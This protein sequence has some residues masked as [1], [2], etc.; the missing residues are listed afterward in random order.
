MIYKKLLKKL[1]FLPIFLFIPFIINAQTIALT[2]KVTDEKGDPLPGASVS[3]KSSG[4]GTSTDQ[5]GSFR[6]SAKDKNE[7]LVVS[8]V[9]FEKQEVR[10]NNRQ[11]FN[12]Q[13]KQDTRQLNEV[14]VVG[15]GTQRRRDLTG[16][17]SSVKGDIFKNQPITNP[18]EALQGRI[19]GVDIVKTS[20]APD[21]SPS[22]II[23]GLSSLNQPNPLYIVDGVRVPDANNIN[24]QD[25]GSIDV[26]KDASSAAI[27]GAAAAGGVILITT[28]KGSGAAPVVNFN[29]RYGSTEPKVISLLGKTDYIKLQDIINP[30]FFTGATSLDTLANTDWVNALYH[31]AN[32]Q[33]YNVSVNGSSP[34]VN[35]LISGFYNKQEGV[36]MKNFSNIGGARVNTDYKLGRWFKFGQQ[37]ALSQ[38]KTAPPIGIEAQ[39]HNAPFRTVPIIPLKN[40]NGTYGTTPPGYNGFS[41]NG[42]NPYGAANLADVENFKNN[43]QA[44]VYAEVKLP[45]SFS[46]RTNFGYSYYH[47]TQ[48]Y[49]QNPF[50]FGAVKNSNNSLNKQSIESTQLLGNGILTFDRSIGKHNINAV[51]GYEQISNV[52]NNINVTAS[53][54]GLPG[55]SVIPTSSTAYQ[56]NGKVDKNGLIKSFFGRLNY[57]FNSRYYIE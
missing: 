46:F 44:N 20:G 42:P 1:F 30:Q 18:T 6:I 25:I 27:Y 29:A 13:L 40:A 53:N 22:I 26:L 43:L 12:I 52:Y 5:N 28:K 8:S 11:N 2:G 47:E 54:I 41:F 23:R 32:E 45:L 15:Y 4:A 33:N 31:N 14:V 37:L 56:V 50:D 38:R 19:A 55:Y 57:N 3:I 24:I 49:F 51:A 35:Y 21:A 10:I 9:G 48:D 36:Y 17:V 16:S 34:A 7:V 39:L